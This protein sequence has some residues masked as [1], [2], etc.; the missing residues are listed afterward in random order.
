MLGHVRHGSHPDLVN[1]MVD[2]HFT[3]VVPLALCLWLFVRAGPEIA[4]N[5]YQP[6]DNHKTVSEVVVLMFS[7]AVCV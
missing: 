7:K 4:V 6:A 3:L 1:I 5:I 2:S